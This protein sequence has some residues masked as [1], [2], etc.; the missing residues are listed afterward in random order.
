M[1]V[2][3]ESVPFLDLFFRVLFSPLLFNTLAFF[4]R[5]LLTG[6]SP[7]PPPFGV[8]GRLPTPFL[9]RR[10]LA[11]SPSSSTSYLSRPGARKGWNPAD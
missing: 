5:F 10:P 1:S 9:D 8:P 3:P 7:F 6:V 4:Y 11:M 2:P